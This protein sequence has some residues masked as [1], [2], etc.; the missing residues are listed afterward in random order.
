MPATENV[1]PLGN[2]TE[3]TSAGVLLMFNDDVSPADRGRVIAGIE[4]V[5]SY[6]ADQNETPPEL[7]CVDVRVTESSLAGS[8]NATGTHV[9]MYTTMEG[10]TTPLSWHLQMVTAHEYLHTW[11]YELSGKA[12]PGGP[13]WLI[14]GAAQLIAVRSMISAG[15]LSVDEAQS[16]M[17]RPSGLLVPALQNLE[18]PESFDIV[19]APYDLV[20][21]AAD[22]LTSESG[23]AGLKRYWT[24]VGR[25][26]AWQDA[27]EPAFGL[28]PAAFY[29]RFEHSPIRGFGVRPH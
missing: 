29:E 23:I 17:T 4:A 18:D 16:L 9:V 3:Q 5:R 28:T 15:M 25:G 13:T 8:A 20:C 7:V 6:F 10:W 12:P 24:D 1:V 21:A 26:I 11:Q 27:F 19:N 2:H 14:E 22:L